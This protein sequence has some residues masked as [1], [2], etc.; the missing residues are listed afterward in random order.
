MD[1]HA[2]ELADK[3]V[4]VFGSVGNPARAHNDIFLLLQKATPEGLPYFYLA[5]GIGDS[6]LSVNREFVAELS[7]RNLRYEYHETPG[8][9]AWDYWDRGIKSM[10]SVMEHRLSTSWA[11]L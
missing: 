5:C 4:E 6:F 1:R 3:V 11:D 7:Q 10:L 2:P 9:H 8:D